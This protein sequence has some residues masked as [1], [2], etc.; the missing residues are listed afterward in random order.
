VCAIRGIKPES[1]RA[2]LKA[3]GHGL[4]GVVA[5]QVV[6][7]GANADL[8]LFADMAR[9]DLLSQEGIHPLEIEEHPF[10]FRLKRP[11]RK[12]C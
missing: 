12:T 10:E 5:A 11:P 6:M 3:H 2:G 4:K 1:A 8:A 9:P 7:V